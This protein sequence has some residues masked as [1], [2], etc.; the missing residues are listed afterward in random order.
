MTAAQQ[1]TGRRS[2]DLRGTGERKG[3]MDRIIE[4][5]AS[6]LG[7]TVG[8]LAS[9]GILLMIFAV[10]WAAFAVALVWSQG[11]LDAAWQSIRGWPLVLQGLAWLLFLPVMVGMWIWETTWPLVWRLVL[12]V[13]IA[14][15]NLLVMIPGKVA[16]AAV[17]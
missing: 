14:G 11:S 10:M 7:N 5:L 13:G 17:I 3:P 9:S 2:V 8:F 16:G 6:G 1:G 12:I 15:W 4:A